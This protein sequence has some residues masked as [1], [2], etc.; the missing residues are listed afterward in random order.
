MSFKHGGEG[1]FPRAEN[2]GRPGFKEILA[3]ALCKNSFQQESRH[4]DDAREVDRNASR[5]G[6]MRDDG[7]AGSSLPGGSA[8]VQY[9]R[10]SGRAPGR[11]RRAD[12]ACRLVAIRACF[13][14]IRN[15]RGSK[16]F[17]ALQAPSGFSIALDGERNSATRS[18][19]GPCSNIA[20]RWEQSGNS[21]FEHRPHWAF[22]P[23]FY[24]LA[25][26]CAA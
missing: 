15:V 20:P 22:K 8:G 4:D 11:A 3:Q 19:L 12:S 1:R 25:P 21:R 24:R 18:A 23:F 13:A 7:R 5:D 9:R 2:Q 10:C 26:S 6:Q 16:I 17:A 14:L